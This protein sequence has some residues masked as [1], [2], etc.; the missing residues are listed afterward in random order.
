MSFSCIIAVPKYY[1][2]FERL[3]NELVTIV[4]TTIGWVCAGFYKINMILPFFSFDQEKYN[5]CGG[6]RFIATSHSSFPLPF[7]SVTFVPSYAERKKEL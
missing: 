5:K 7:P 3:K 6:A 2:K 4:T 1:V